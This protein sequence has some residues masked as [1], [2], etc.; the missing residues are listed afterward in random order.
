M[1][2]QASLTQRDIDASASSPAQRGAQ[3]ASAG[4]RRSSGARSVER[5]RR[6][7]FTVQIPKEQRDKDLERTLATELPGILA[8]AVQGCLDWRKCN[9]L[10]EPGRLLSRR[11]RITAVRW[12]M[13]AAFSRR[14]A[15][16]AIPTPIKYRQPP[17]STPFIGGQVIAR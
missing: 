10:Q 8:W 13:W 6:I 1:G 3:P 4:G 11:R 14:C 17:C 2:Y 5:I 12:M 9:D 16:W 15:S 7:P